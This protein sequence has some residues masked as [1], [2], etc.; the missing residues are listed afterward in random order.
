M[1][2]HE[3][4]SDPE[5]TGRAELINRIDELENLLAKKKAE[6]KKRQGPRLK[7]GTDGIP[8]L[9]ELVDEN[10]PI[11]E[12]SS[13]V[14]EQRDNNDVINEI[15]DKVDHEISQDLDELIVMLKDSIIDEVKTRLLKELASEHKDPAKQR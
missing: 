9:D 7:F 11:S 1:A 15:I 2:E 10:A 13:I 8:V 4:K 3:G 14:N 5:K 6:S 12:E